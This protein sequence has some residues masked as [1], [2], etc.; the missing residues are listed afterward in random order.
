[1]NPLREL[2]RNGQSVW[3][4]SIR[5]SLL[6][7][8]ELKRL[9]E[10]DGVSGI[11][12]NPAIF[13]KAISGSPGNND[14]ADLLLALQEKTA[15]PMKVYE[16]LAVRDI[17]DAAEVLRPVYEKSNRRDGYVSLEVSPFLAYHT[18]E[19]VGEAR[20]LWRAVG[21]ENLMIKVPGTP[22]GIP[23]FE[24][25]ISEGINVNVTLL[26][27]RAVYE[28]VA[29]AYLAGLE[30]FAAQGGDLGR[31]ASV[32]SFFVSRIDTSV[33]SILKARSKNATPS[34]Q[35]VLRGLLG[36]TAIANA[37][38]AYRLYREIFSGPRWQT[39]ES[40]GAR[41]QRPEGESPP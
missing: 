39:L 20:R 34:E 33:D 19:T 30:K 2:S 11:T 15:D 14:Y 3:L 23:A 18:A 37:K 27:S 10:Q 40:K 35:D 16:E 7:S 6:T 21:R 25:L 38:L 26:F 8:G 12:S 5:R 29:L 28:Q 9:V 41:A 31:M 22:E 17:Q 24:Q 36:K 32:A 1:M 13:E 4:D